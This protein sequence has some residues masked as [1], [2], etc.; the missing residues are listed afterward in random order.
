MAFIYWSNGPLCILV[1]YLLLFGCNSNLDRNN[2]I[3]AEVKRVIS[4]Q[5]VEVTL[6]GEST[7]TKVRIIG[8]DAPD[9]RQAPWGENAKTRLSELVA[10]Q[11]VNLEIEDEETNNN[12][13][14]RIYAHIWQDNNLI[15]EKLVK[16]G[17]VLANTKYPHSYSKLLINTQEYARLMGYGIW[18]PQQALRETPNQFRSKNK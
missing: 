11:Q 14:N 17:C 2:L 15:S 3:A 13:Y 18:N 1:F 5:T 16:E 6:P 8:I 9:L 4:G 7:S 12:P 10:G